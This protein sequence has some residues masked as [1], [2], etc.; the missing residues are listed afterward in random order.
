MANINEQVLIDGVQWRVESF[1]LLDMVLL[2]QDE[3]K[4]R[5]T[6]HRSQIEPV[7]KVGDDVCHK[8]KMRKVTLVGYNKQRERMYYGLEGL[9]TVV[10][11]EEL[12]VLQ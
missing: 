6:C 2:V 1:D 11:F 12:E 9:V 5:R 4:A 10:P 7:V 3:T 8:G